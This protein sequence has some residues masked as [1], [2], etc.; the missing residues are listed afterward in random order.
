MR[1]RDGGL[2]GKDHLENRRREKLILT[3]ASGKESFPRE[4]AFEPLDEVP[5]VVGRIGQEPAF[6]RGSSLVGE[7]CWVASQIHEVVFV[8]GMG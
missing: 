5:S 6:Q 7:G 8:P 4:V 1:V 2:E 3:E